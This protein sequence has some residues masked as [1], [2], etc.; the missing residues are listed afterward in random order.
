M[1]KCSKCKT[2]KPVSQFSKNKYKKDGLQSQCKECNIETSKT[3]NATNPEKERDRNLKRNYGIDLQEYNQMFAQQ[4]GCCAICGKHQTEFKTKLAVD[5]CHT[6]G[7]VRGLLCSNCN[8]GIGYL[9]DSDELFSAASQYLNKDPRMQI[10]TVI[11]F[12]LSP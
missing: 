9:K 2:E 12:K 3:W 4:S 8:I 6:S 7:E 10:C 1:K 11:D 5:H